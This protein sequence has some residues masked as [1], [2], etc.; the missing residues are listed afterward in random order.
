MKLF[1]KGQELPALFISVLVIALIVLVVAAACNPGP[2]P[3][4]GGTTPPPPPPGGSTTVPPPPPPPSNDCTFTVADLTGYNQALSSA[5]P[6]NVVCVSGGFESTRLKVSAPGVAV[7]GVNNPTVQGIDVTG[8]GA[9]VD[10]FQVLGA[11]AP[12]V[13]ITGNDSTTQNL[14]ID[15]PTGGDYDG[16]RFFGTGIKI[17]H[18]TIRHITNTHGAHADCMQTFATGGDSVAS[19]NVL[20]EGNRCENIDN[21]CLIAEGPNSEAGDGSGV[22]ESKN[23][24]FRNNFCEGH[25]SQDLMIDDVQNLT[26]T[27]N[28][29]ANGVDHAIALQNKS[30]GAVIKDNSVDPGIECIVGMDKSSKPGYQG[31]ESTCGP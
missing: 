30:T 29:F 22:G 9:T 21:Q 20:I 28:T 2:A 16:I 24:V 5:K 31:P 3:S 19:Q 10:G 12:G 27:G 1:R 25:A 15:H 14:T 11:K 18:N 4:G 26:V 23:I 8:Q 7:R 6:G 13:Y 17:L